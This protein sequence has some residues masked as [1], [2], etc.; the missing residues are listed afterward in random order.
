MRMSSWKRGEGV[1]ERAK[2][3]VRTGFLVGLLAGVAMVLFIVALR[4]ALGSSSL[5]EALAD[6][7]TIITLPQ[8]FVLLLTTL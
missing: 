4:L 6:W 7:F 8:V 1:N 3:R 2:G 5:L